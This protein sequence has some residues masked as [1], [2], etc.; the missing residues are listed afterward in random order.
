MAQAEVGD[1]V[2]GDDPTVN[3]LEKM[4]AERLGKEASLFVTSGTQSNLC[5]LLVHCSRGDEYIAGD[6]SHTFRY[7]G[8]GG[9][10]L[11][12]ISPQPVATLADG[13]PDPAA[14]LAAIKP[15]DNHFARTRLLCLENTKDGK[16]QSRESMESAIEA[17]RQGGLSVHLDGARMWNACAELGISGAELVAGVDTVS[18]CLSKGLG[19]VAGSL[20]SGPAPLIEE[21]RKWRKMLGGGLRQ[22]GVLAAAGIYAL[23][24]HIDRLSEDH[25][26]ASRLAS[27][28]SEIDG[29]EIDAQDTNMV[30]AT[31]SGA[32]ADLAERMRSRGVLCSVENVAYRDD[33]TPPG[34]Q[35]VDHASVAPER[36]SLL[37]LVTHL[38]ICDHD[39]SVVVAAFAAELGA[40]S[41]TT[42]ITMGTA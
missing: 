33:S 13:L 39:I 16:V 9:A 7:E 21:A 30:F 36:L 14:V 1:D 29:I 40:S 34:G 8:G 15:D 6:T 22:A 5:A 3:R 12:G 11:G 41:T 26:R 18:M 31:I 42:P 23:E 27:E 32:R 2:Y 38:D 4:V 24:H 20:L 37:R 10:V 19:A 25:D 17:A 35:P 28:L